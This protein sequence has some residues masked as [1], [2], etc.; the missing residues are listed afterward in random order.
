MIAKNNTLI[1]G[2][3]LVRKGETFNKSDI[4]KLGLKEPKEKTPKDKT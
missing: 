1:P 4:K 3:R 2:G